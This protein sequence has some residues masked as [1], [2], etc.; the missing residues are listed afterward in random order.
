MILCG[1][2]LYGYVMHLVFR[3]ENK[4]KEERWEAEV[5]R[6]TRLSK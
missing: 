6:V 4:R 2:T 3:E 1:E 5:E